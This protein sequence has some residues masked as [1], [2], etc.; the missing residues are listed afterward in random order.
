MR[1]L[2]RGGWFAL[3]GGVLILALLVSGVVVAFQKGALT[4]RGENGLPGF[5]APSPVSATGIYREGLVGTPTMLDPLLATSQPDRDLSALLFNGLTRG[6]GRGGSQP[7]L[8]RSWRIEDG[9]K[10]YVF[11]L[12]DDVTWHDGRKF[13]ARDVL[14]TLQLIQDPGFPGDRALADLWRTVKVEAPNDYT[15]VCTLPNVYAPFL[16]YTT[17]GILPAHLLADVKAGDLPN[18]AFNLR[19]VGTGPF[20]FVNLDPNKVEIALQRYDGYF[21]AKPHLTGLRFRFYATTP[22]AIQ[23]MQAGEVDGLGY[24]PAQYLG[25]AAQAI[26]ATANIYGPSIAGYTALFFNLKLPV[27]ATREVRQALALAVNRDELVK[28]GLGGWGTPGSSPILPTSWAY[29]TTG[30]TQYP[31]DPERAR[32]M[33]EQ[34][35]W[36]VGASGAREKGGQAL[37]FTLLTDNDPGRVAVANLLATQF[38][39]IGCKVT[40]QAVAADVAAQAL[41]QRQFEAALSGW[42]GLASDPDPYQ[43]WHSSQADSGYNFANYSNPQADEALAQARL[44]VDRAKRAADYATFLKLFSEDV[45]SIVLYYPQYHFAVTKRVS[46]VSLDP[47]DEPSDR[48][49]NIA[50]WTIGPP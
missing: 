36:K 9:G 5:G 2:S 27:F 7:D 30:V 29:T 18:E 21:G 44:T 16:A 22:A 11:T 25:A 50:D 39:A 19:P 13:T 12:R 49:R 8:A 35:G 10:R 42:V 34:A 45:P 23:G 46:G 28:Q 41:A 1:R 20:R 6:D 33:L 4:T 37:A 14:F 47:L 38:G 32:Q 17:V 48:F 15:I 40:V 26:G 31:F 43:M 24:V 3:V